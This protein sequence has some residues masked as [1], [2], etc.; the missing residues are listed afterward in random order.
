[1][2]YKLQL[3][4]YVNCNHFSLSTIFKTFAKAYVKGIQRIGEGDDFMNDMTNQ[5]IVRF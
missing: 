4:N 3:C 1:M 5:P 2:N